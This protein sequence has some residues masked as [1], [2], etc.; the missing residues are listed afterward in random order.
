MMLKCIYGAAGTGKT[1]YMYEKIRENSKNGS[2]SYI[3]V[4]EQYS[5]DTER[6]IIKR[7]GLSSQ[8]TVEVM[9]F[10]RLCNMVFGECG[11]LR[12]KYIDKA[13]KIFVISRALSEIGEKL[14]YYGRNV[15]QKGFASMVLSLIGELRR[16]G[17][18]ADMLSA[19]A[20]NITLK[21]FS[22]KIS[23]IALI[24]REYDRLLSEKYSDAEE[25]LFKAVPNISRCKFIQG[26][27]F[28]YGFKSFTPLEHSAIC[29]IMK[30]ADVTAVLRC[31]RLDE[32]D[33]IFSSACHTF[34]RLKED[35]A[36]VGT[37]T[38]ACIAP[39]CDTAFRKNP[40]LLHL[41][42]NYFAYPYNIY[43]EETQSV[44][45]VLAKDSFDE[46]RQCAALIS[47]LCRENGYRFSDFLVLLR[48]RESIRSVLGAVFEEF[49]INCF[50][51]DKKNLC[52]NPFVLKILSALE[53]LAY[54][55]S[56][57]RIMKVVRFES[58]DYNMAEADV[59]ENYIL[60]S[61]ISHKYWNSL[62]DWEFNPDP[63]R[64]SLDV[65]NKVKRA[66]VN[67]I[68]EMK[69]SFSGR[70]TV[71]AIGAALVAWMKNQKMDKIINIMSAEFAKNGNNVLALEYIRAWN[72]F[73]SVLT[74]L[75]DCM[76]LEYITFVKFSEMLSAACT[77]VNIAVAP[78]VSDG[79]TVEDIDTFRKSDAKVVIALGLSDGV[80]PK[81]YAE[82]GM[83]SDIEREELLGK[84]IEL[85]PTADFKRRE[86][87]SLVYSVLTA[88]S[89]KLYLSCPRTDK[90]GKAIA[91]SEVIGRVKDI[92]P[93][94][95]VIDIDISQG[96]SF[97]AALNSLLGEIAAHRGEISELP[98]QQKELFDWFC[99][100]NAVKVEIYAFA[101]SIKNYDEAK[102]LSKDMA[103][104]LY[105]RKMMLS[106]SKAEKYNSCA[107]SYFMRYG[108]IAN[109][110]LRAGVEANNVG[111]VLHETLCRYFSEL[112]RNDADYAAITYE[113]VCKRVGEIAEKVA[114][115]QD[116]LLYETSP[117]YRYV[118]LRIKS[119]AS[120]TAWEIVRFYAS[121]AFRPYGFEV[122]IGENGDFPGL[123]F[124]VEDVTVSVNGAIDRID[125]AEI[126]KKNYVSIVDYKSSKKDTDET[127]E[128]AGV[129]I[130]PLVYAGIACKNLNATPAAMMYV[131][132]N[133]PIINFDAVPDD[134]QL[135]KARRKEIGTYG[136]FDG[137]E[138][139]AQ[140]LD[141]RPDGY[142]PRSRHSREN[143]K[144]LE[145]R[146]KN[147]EEK[148]C[149]TAEKIIDGDISIKP[150]ITKKYN[151]CKYCDYFGI[152]GRTKQV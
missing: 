76:G 7:L 52:E 63:K 137:S 39:E 66:A 20:E 72:A 13:G 110:R 19:A 90:E 17:V 51:G 59:F 71:Q 93:N 10:S 78:P 5:M 82:E 3:L 140:S 37:K 1:E 103:K 47:K 117:Y 38:G 34:K 85:A 91:I 132:M 130:Q 111:S 83:L 109:K 108:L 23:D 57:E 4:P 96:E 35:A 73:S 32:V 26:E 61:N 118:A 101:E 147:A 54:G 123:T 42:K 74:Q 89:E 9:T 116:R 114:A 119:V 113:A 25:N 16:Y 125:K 106:V 84:G 67:P 112:S 145:A 95:N 2:K 136:I 87:Q 128:N 46:A 107:F 56:A 44:N 18:T 88:A 40:A 43:K 8:L 53:I 6:E 144:T 143:N 41:E 27:V 49:S 22:D 29:E 126:D 150:Y 97:S 121:S 120:A 149:E 152:C 129:Q 98:K 77:E 148:L 79:V 75:A 131:H 45:V 135:E 104:E 80:F 70:K 92:F 124:S 81:G 65:V 64:I 36:A 11:P 33:G 50:F 30:N 138:V 62:D 99:E 48:N 15:H 102:P 60:A 94:V 69:N 133:D 115:E 134:E 141:S 139:V 28:L 55:F 146:I 142:V 31:S 100:N 24:Y 105:G 86:E 127:L 58:F 151:A 122:K 12:L 21:R 14:L 68:I